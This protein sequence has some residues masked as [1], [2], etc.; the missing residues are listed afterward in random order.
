[1]LKNKKKQKKLNPIAKDLGT[2]KYRMRVVKNKKIY[3]TKILKYCNYYRNPEQIE[4]LQKLSSCQR[5]SIV[6]TRQFVRS[7][8]NLKVC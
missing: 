1:M 7:L 2:P 5:I 6:D 8:I 4:K 3:T